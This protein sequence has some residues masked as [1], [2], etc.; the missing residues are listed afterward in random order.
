MNTSNPIQY[1]LGGSYPEAKLIYSKEIEAA[2]DE[3]TGKPLI[4]F[5]NPTVI[6][7]GNDSYTQQDV[8]AGYYC[9]GALRTKDISEGFTY[10]CRN[11]DESKTTQCN[12]QLWNGSMSIVF[13]S[14]STSS[15]QN[16]NQYNPYTTS[17]QFVEYVYSISSSAYPNSGVS[18][19][20]YY[21][22]RTTITSPTAPTALTYPSTITT[23]S[24]DV[25]WT[26]SI[27]NVPAYAVTGYEVSYAVNGQSTWTVAGTPTGT[28][29][30]V[31]ILPTATSIQFRVRA[32]DS[33]N[34][35]SS[36]AT[37][38]TSQ[39]LISPT[40]TVP[41]L[42]MQGQEITVNWTA[43]TGAT[44]YTLQRKANTDDGWQQVYSGSDLTFTEMAGAWTS[45][46]YQVQAVFSSGSGGWATS[47]S[48][49]VIA[50]SVLVISG[51]DSDLGTITSDIPYTVSSDTG[52]D[53]TLTRTVNGVLVAS[54]TVQS[55]FAYNIPVVDLPTGTGT[56]VISASVTASSETVTAT[57]TWTYT[58][59]TMAFP[60]SAGIGQLSQN[61]QNI[62]PMTV[63][64]AIKTPAY[65]GGDLGKALN[66]LSRAVLY[67]QNQIAKYSEVNI[68][69]S[70]VSVG[71]EV[72]LPYNGVMVPH[73][74][75]QIGNPD[76]EMYDASCDG[77]WLLRKDCVAQG[78]W[79]SSGVNTLD[80][81]TIMTTMQGYVANYDSTV[82][83]SIQTVKIPYHI[84]DG[85]D[86]INILSNG[87]QCKI[88]PLSAY[89]VGFLQSDSSGI[90]I[91]GAK[92]N[93]FELGKASTSNNKRIANYNDAPFS[94]WLRS[95]SIGVD[96]TNANKT[97]AW[98]VST[99]G[100]NAGYSCTYSYGYRP[101]FIMP[102][103]FTATYLVDKEGN[104]GTEQEYISSGSYEDILGNTI[105]VP[106]IETGS[107]T[108]T[109]TTDQKSLT[110]SFTP[111]LVFIF[112]GEQ[113]GTP[114]LGYAI[115]NSNSPYYQVWVSDGLAQ[116][117]FFGYG[118]VTFSSNSVAWKEEFIYGFRISGSTITASTPS[119]DVSYALNLNLENTVYTYIAIG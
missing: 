46:Q 28:S 18:G 9:A 14:T 115:F 31:A 64:D 80:G 56:I 24:V 100:T 47:A 72:N 89:E 95:S 51:T 35:W 7:M 104:V 4:Y 13:R 61:G 110:F 79:N 3:A 91:D 84:G 60:N 27:N 57:R 112:P 20:Y 62:W 50:A 71:D 63:P 8:P 38:S 97:H 36:Y 39:V 34:Q 49:P 15:T 1:S 86:A 52:N 111:K 78:Q 54:L 114:T 44:S 10:V 26:A 17:G 101:C 92:L 90:P 32:K 94:W 70:N 37:G 67:N 96:S 107:Y 74:V 40:L 87:L 113:Q 116:Y 25:T 69:L 43:V 98:S 12:Y 105:P 109:G 82:Q 45:V 42:A 29:L 53:I 41:S 81:S 5:V 33:N 19:D 85:N 83:A 117:S 103:T 108:G 55:G 102:T 106:K 99:K 75:V 73:I 48:I 22:Q 58:K 88:F 93:Y 77:V 30:T 119:V 6:N 68:N 11:A 2:Y 59:T 16:M 76:A 118:T 23:T 65:M 66:Q 21:G